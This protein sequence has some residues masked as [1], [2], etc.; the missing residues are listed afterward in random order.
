MHLTERFDSK[1]IFNYESHSCWFSKFKA[2][3][4][5]EPNMYSFNIKIFIYMYLDLC[6]S[7]PLFPKRSHNFANITTISLMTAHLKAMSN[8]LPS[9]YYPTNACLNPSNSMLWDTE[10]CILSLNY[11]HNSCTFK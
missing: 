7:N 8:T 3:I 11:G 2:H 5:Q 9:L 1:S 6:S 10:C 4:I